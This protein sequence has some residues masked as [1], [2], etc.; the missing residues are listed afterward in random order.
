MSD[1][2]PAVRLP[3]SAELPPAALAAYLARQRWSGARGAPL[4]AVRL[5]ALL[6]L[7]L[8][9]P[10]GGAA[11]AAACALA[12]VDAR[13]GGEAVRYQLPLVV[14]P[15]TALGPT[16]RDVVCYVPLPEGGQGAVIDATYE[17][18][19]R[20]GLLAALVHGTTAAD[21]GLA[22]RAVAEP[23]GAARLASVRDSRLGGAEQSNTSVLYGE[24]AILKLFRRLAPGV[25]PDVEIGRALSRRGFAHVPPLLGVLELDGD[26][27]P[28]VAGMV[29]IRG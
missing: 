18:E 21:A 15:A 11:P 22:W 25:Q 4:D 8:P 27:G 6:P 10:D 26:A 13:V 24:V 7:P 3:T 28:A 23:G 16:V 5:S 19:V 2:P 1:G 17:P 9:A 14:R 12:L 29:R 20:L